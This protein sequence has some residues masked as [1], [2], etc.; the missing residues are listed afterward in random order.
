[1]PVNAMSQSCVRG[2]SLMGI[3]AVRRVGAA[4]VGGVQRVGG[5]RD[6]G[7]VVRAELRLHS[8]QRHGGASPRRGPWIAA[9]SRDSHRPDA[10]VKEALVAIQLLHVLRGALVRV[11][12][13]GLVGTKIEGD[14]AGPRCDLAGPLTEGDGHALRVRGDQQLRA[15]QLLVEEALDLRADIGRRA[16]PSARQVPDGIDFQAR[17]PA[18]RDGHACVLFDAEHQDLHGIVVVPT[19]LRRDLDVEE[20]ALLVEHAQLLGQV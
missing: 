5:Q 16:R 20:P 9:R 13:V 15:R 3:D 11:G 12:D 19:Q 1:M 7:S 10:G 17:V 8:R 2:P 6:A 18:R 4:G 14:G